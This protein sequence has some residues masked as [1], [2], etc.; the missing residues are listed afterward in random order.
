MEILLMKVSNVTA[1]IS[2]AFA[3]LGAAAVYG[4]DV[5]FCVVGR[6]ALTR[7]SDAALVETMGERGRVTRELVDAGLSEQQIRSRL[8]ALSPPVA[9]EENLGRARDPDSIQDRAP[10][11]VHGGF[12]GDRGAL[13]R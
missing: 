2:L 1:M 7:V 6:T 13:C 9:L 4:T 5:F 8:A 10:R 12:L 3:L 11:H